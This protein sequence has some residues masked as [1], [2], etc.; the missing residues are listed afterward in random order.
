MSS[1]RNIIHSIKSGEKTIHVGGIFG[2]AKAYLLAKLAESFEGKT[3]AVICPTEDRSHTLASDAGLFIQGGAGKRLH[4][5]PDS[6]V[7]P[8]IKLSPEPVRWADR[9]ELLNELKGGEPMVLITSIAAAA[10]SVAPKRFLTQSTRALSLKENVDREELARWLA[11]HGY[12]DVGLVED[13][14]S[15]AVRGGIIDLWTPTLPDPV[16]LELDGE[17]LVSIRTFDPANQRSRGELREIVIIPASEIRFEPDVIDRVLEKI[18]RRADDIDFPTQER[19]QINEMLKE[20][21]SF[22]GIETL[23]PLFH[24]ETSSLID[25]L[26]PD[27]LLIIDEPEEVKHSSAAHR[28]KILDLHNQSSSIEKIVAPDELYRSAD[29]IMASGESLQQIHLH[30]PESIQSD[31]ASTIM[32]NTQPTVELRSLAMQGAHDRDSISPLSTTIE[33]WKS[34]GLRTIFVCH[35]EIQA[36][37]LVDLFRWHGISLTSY[38]RQIDQALEGTSTRPSVVVGRLSEGFVWPDEKIALVIDEEIF[39][40]KIATRVAKKPP[41]E[42][43]TSF[44][45]LAEGDAL[46]HEN[47]GIG[48][49]LGLKHLRIQDTEGDYL[50][51]E[52]LGGDKLYVPVYRM[53]FIQRY[54]GA[55]DAEPILDKLGGTRWSKIKKS[56]RKAIMAMAKDLLRVQAAREMYPGFRFPPADSNYEEFCAVFPY[57]ET[58]DQQSAIDD[59]LR[60]MEVEKPMDRLVCGDVGYGKTEVAMRAAFKAALAGKQVVILV[61]TT[62]LAMQHYETFTERFSNTPVTIDMLSRFRTYKQQK[63]IVSEVKKGTMDIVIGTHRLLSKDVGFK[64]LGLLIVDEEQRFGVKHKE[65]LKKLKE[66]VDVMSL[67]ATPIPRTLHFSLVGI[68]DISIINTPPADRH[69]ITT[70]VVPFDEGLIRHAI[71]NEINRGGQVFFVHNR[72]QTMKSMLA[73]LVRLVP[74]AGMNMAHGQMSERELE[75][76]MIDFLEKRFNVLVCTAIIESGLDIPSANTI[77]VNRADTF[78]LAQ[79]YQLRGRVGRSDVLAYAYLLTPQDAVMTPQAKKRLIVLKRFTELGSGFQIASH[80]LEIR[81]GGNILGAAQS[82]H[83]AQVGYELYTKLLAREIRRL[84]GKEIEEDIDPELKLKVEAY[85]PKNYIEEPGTRLDSYRRLASCENESEVQDIAKE[86]EDRFGPLPVEAKRLV[87][88]MA[89]KV[90]AQRLRIRQLTFDGRLFA[91]Q[92]DS[93]TPLDPTTAAKLALTSPERFRLHPPDKLI[94]KTEETTNPDVILEEARKF[95]STLESYAN[96]TTQKG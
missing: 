50:L 11:E 6:D 31:G 7:L 77:I 60:D 21:I 42:A 75:E 64:D 2:S 1:I 91:C 84:T 15:F 16:R 47:H 49:Y 89:I 38:D 74:E 61:P 40:R 22:P 52:Y 93:T 35:T 44:A 76:V 19:R 57:D 58:P 3:I 8:Y 70:H 90:A 67:T 56:V 26:P 86:I 27:A 36:Q 65:K 95:L 5:F 94:F 32:V 78:G 41:M 81:G 4:S 18:K 14:G 80:D 24:E 71:L 37:R 69:S 46:V 20:G 79:L 13:E 45:E 43:F 73:R 92:L 88:I 30:V 29:R 33:S 82:G 12:V 96:P 39:G 55:G 25:Y 66:T 62:I 48:R 83:I 23:S 9:I 54:V 53:N 85:F 17:E 68:R 87:G 59:V 28:E 34:K 10:R 72:V 51:L 63:K